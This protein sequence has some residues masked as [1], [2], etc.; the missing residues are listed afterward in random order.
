MNTEPQ[1]NNQYDIKNHDSKKWRPIAITIGWMLVIILVI[2]WFCY[3]NFRE[4]K[5]RY[6]I[7]LQ[8]SVNAFIL[9]AM[10][11]Q[12]GVT[13]LQWS[14]MRKGLKRTDE[15][16]EQNKQTLI[17]SQRA[18]VTAAIDKILPMS[19]GGDFCLRIENGGNTPANAVV[20]F[21]NINYMENP[22]E[23]CKL[24]K[25]GEMVAIDIGIGKSIGV[26]APKSAYILPIVFPEVS[27]KDKWQL[28]Q[29]KLYCWGTIEYTD[30]FRDGRRQSSYAFFQSWE[31]LDG[32]P[33]EAGNEAY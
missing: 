10:F 27:D 32:H 24:P 22:P 17:Y 19:Y 33:C 18:Y 29:L 11:I 7:F 20:V 8:V 23:G 21:Y 12:I 31:F 30:V 1:K 15:A 26:I 5:E 16:I 28:N 25:E 13:R 6:E 14:A 3:A 4:P 2:A 9:L